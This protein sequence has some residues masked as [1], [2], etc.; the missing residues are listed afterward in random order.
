MGSIALVGSVSDLDA[1]EVSGYSEEL[2]RTMR[3]LSEKLGNN[4]LVVAIPPVLLGGVKSLRL[5]RTIIETK[6]WLRV[7]SRV[8]PHFCFGSEI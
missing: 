4:V 7:W 5:V 6:L 8:R 1:Q 3:I 2:A